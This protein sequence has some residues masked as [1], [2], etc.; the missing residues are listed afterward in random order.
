M[1]DEDREIAR[2]VIA[3]ELDTPS[4]YM[5]RSLR[6]FAAEG[7]THHPGARA[8]SHHADSEGHK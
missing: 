2:E 8:A 1:T 3:R 6:P 5:G 4:V 7:R